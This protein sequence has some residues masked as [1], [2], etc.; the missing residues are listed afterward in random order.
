MAMQA[1]SDWGD[2]RFQA[3]L[4]LLE[5]LSFA[6]SHL[7]AWVNADISFRCLSSAPDMMALLAVSSCRWAAHCD[8]G[9]LPFV[10]DPHVD[11]RQS[12]ARLKCRR[13]RVCTNLDVNRPQ[14]IILLVMA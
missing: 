12:A 8:F 10:P 11:S 9:M 13:T 3:P 1:G 5:L 14:D 4:K 6:I 2:E 7:P